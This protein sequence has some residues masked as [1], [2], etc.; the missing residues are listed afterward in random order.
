MK[1]RIIIAGLQGM[2]V[3]IANGNDFQPIAIRVGDE[4]DAHRFVFIADAAHF[5]MQRV[6]RIKIFCTESQME[7]ALTKVIALGMIAQPGQF[8][9]EIRGVVAQESDDERAISCR[10]AAHFVQ[11]ERLS[12]ECDGGIKIGDVVVLVNHFEVHG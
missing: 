3:L 4:I 1:F 7:F 2:F 5:L 6:C 11:A 8:Q 9:F 10:L 12:V